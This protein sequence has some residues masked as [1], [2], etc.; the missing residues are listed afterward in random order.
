MS[1]DYYDILG[2]N[3]SAN[4]SEIKKAYRKLA[5]KY[6]PDKNPDN[7]AAEEKFKEIS[8]AYEVLSDPEKKKTYDR[9]GTVDPNMGGGFHNPHDIFERFAR[10]Q[11]DFMNFGS[12]GGGRGGFMTK[13]PNTRIKVE[14][15]LADAIKGVSKKIKI[16]RKVKCT[17][18]SGTGAKDGT[19]F[20]ICGR[21]NGAGRIQHVTRHGFSQIIQ[22]VSCPECN[23]KGKTITERCDACHGHS[24]IDI[25]DNIDIN[26]PAGVTEGD[27]L[28]QEGY[29]NFKMGADIAGDLLINV[30]VKNDTDFEIYDN[31]LVYHMQLSIFDFVFGTDIE[32]PSPTG[33]KPHKY[34]VKPGSQPNDLLRLRGQGIPIL[35][36]GKPRGDAYCMLDCYIPTQITPEEKEALEVLKNS[37]NFQP[38]N[39]QKK[40]VLK[41]FKNILGAFF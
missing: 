10:A 16:P 40:N 15:S 8:E 21:C 34:K 3:K 7:K 27:V 41:Q 18:C 24:T 11:E 5:V 6:H 36:E 9:F 14:I 28:Q 12:F 22:E 31:H 25:K 2:V 32:I 35:R 26:I 38:K 19:A 37:K 1:K 17:S 33:D 29:G 39:G 13:G 4:E 20:R 23:G 30:H